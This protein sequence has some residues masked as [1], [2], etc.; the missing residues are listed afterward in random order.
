VRKQLSS[1]EVIPA[2]TFTMGSALE[3]STIASSQCTRSI[4]VVCRRH[5]E[6]TLSNGTRTAVVA[7]GGGGGGGRGSVVAVARRLS[8]NRAMNGCPPAI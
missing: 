2:G 1:N 7:D 8:M 5:Y 3:Q 4:R 6:V